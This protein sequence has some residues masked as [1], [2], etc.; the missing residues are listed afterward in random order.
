MHFDE[1]FAKIMEQQKK[2]M[3]PMMQRMTAGMKVSEEDRARVV[4]IQKKVTDEL[5]DSMAGPEMKAAVTEIYS[6]VFSKEELTSLGAFYSTPAGQS[7]V[8]KQP[9]VQEKMMQVMMPKMAEIGPKMQAAMKDFA[10]E[11]KA[12]QQT[13]APAP[14]PA[15]NP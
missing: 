3:A 15:P 6:S 8:A 11:M 10:A 5:F 2:Q 13:Q 1:M 7:M 14:T 9:Q 12:K 4:A